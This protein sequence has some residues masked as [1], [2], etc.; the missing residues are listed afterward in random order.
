[1]E[2][3]E[4]RVHG[5]AK[6]AESDSDCPKD[7][8]V[9]GRE[10]ANPKPRIRAGLTRPRRGSAQTGAQF[11]F[12]LISGGPAAKCRARAGTDRPAPT[13]GK[14]SD[15]ATQGRPLMIVDL[16]LSALLAAQAAP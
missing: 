13:Q 10:P 12:F 9:F 4:L 6:Y 8:L 15:A 5:R 14:A 7:P 2:R 16:R 3:F 1:M 11:P